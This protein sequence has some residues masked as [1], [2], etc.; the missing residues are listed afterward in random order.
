MQA[1]S[2][3]KMSDVSRELNMVDK[4]KD[5]GAQKSRTGVNQIKDKGNNIT[6]TTGKDYWLLELP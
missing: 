5:T 3:V 1:G 4:C 2:D 6:G